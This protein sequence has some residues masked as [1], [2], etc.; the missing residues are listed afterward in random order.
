MARATVSIVLCSV[1]VEYAGRRKKKKI[2]MQISVA[3]SMR[4]EQ[5]S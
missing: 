5:M 4:P 3:F 2:S 1:W